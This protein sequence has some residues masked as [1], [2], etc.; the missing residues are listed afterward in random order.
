MNE[1]SISGGGEANDVT[2]R[3]P[4][5]VK[6]YYML[7]S[8]RIASGTGLTMEITRKGLALPAEDSKPAMFCTLF[9]SRIHVMFYTIYA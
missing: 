9:N 8:N 6:Q 5:E 7:A 2:S 1:L 4:C 3:S